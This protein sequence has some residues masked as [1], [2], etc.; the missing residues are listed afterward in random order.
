VTGSVEIAGIELEPGSPR[1][2]ILQGV[3][4]LSSDRFNE[5]GVPLMTVAENMLL[6]RVERY[7]VRRRG[8]AADIERYMK[9]LTV[10]PDDP[11]APFASL[12]GGNQQKVLLARWLL[13]S[14]RVMLLDDPTAG[15][16]PRTREVIFEQLKA[17]AREGACI[18]L[19]SS[20]PEHLARLCDRVLVVQDGRIVDQLEGA[21]L[22]IEG[23]TH[24]TFA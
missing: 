3:Y 24:A 18:I 22:T 15:V 8:A 5:G 12:S 4:Y 17:L 7:G 6:P 16:D 14:P 21:D 2:A 23:V 1:S 10:N 9:K 11:H 19:R 13:V 20:E